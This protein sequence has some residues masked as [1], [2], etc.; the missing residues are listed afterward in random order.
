MLAYDLSS[1]DVHLLF[2]D[3]SLVIISAVAP[4]LSMD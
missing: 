2:L 1:C 3:I 4:E